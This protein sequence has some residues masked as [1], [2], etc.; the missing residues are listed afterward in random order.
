MNLR[1]SKWTVALALLFLSMLPIGASAQIIK[2]VVVWKTSLQ[3]SDTP[4]KTLVFTATIKSGWHLYDQNLPEDGPT[5]TEFL[6]DKMTGAKLVGK[7]T[8]DKTP[9]DQY[10][11]QFEMN[12]RWYEK[13]VSFRQKI[14]VTDPA[15][16]SIKGGVRFMACNDENCLPPETSDFSF[17]ASMIKSKAAAPITEAE[18]AEADMAAEAVAAEAA[19]D[20]ASQADAAD[21][22]SSKADLWTPVVSELRAYGDDTLKQA[23]SAPWKIF[24]YGF[25][26]GFVALLTPCVWPMIPMTVSFFL[27]RNKDKKKAVRDAF[28][29]GASIIVIYVVLGLLITGIFGVNS[30]NSLATNAV[31]NIIF[32]LLLVVFAISFFG[33]FELVLPSSWTNK[34]D[35]K[36]DSTTGLLSIFFMAFTL[37]LVSFSCTGP[38]IGTLLVQ[39]A[40]AGS[41]LAPAMGMLGFATS[42][43]LPFTLFAV[44]PSWLQ[45]MPKSGGW[46]NMVKVVLGFLELALA[47][48]FL[49]VADLAYGWHI[50]DRETFLALWIVIFALLGCY[51]LG[52]IRFS[53]DSEWPYLSV[54][55]FMMATVSLAFAVYMIPGLWGA[56]LKAVSAFAPPLHTQ[57]FNLY[58]GEVHAHFTDYEAGM[59]FARQENKPVLLDF[60]GHGCVNCRKMEN[61]V[62]IDP[63][64]K[65]M[66]E[67]DYVLI[68]LMVDEKK[69][70]AEPLTIV[71]DG[72]EKTLRT[73]GDKWSYLQSHKFG[74]NAQPFYVAI[75]H[76]GKPLSASYSYNE[77]VPQ[78]VDFLKGGLQEFKKRKNK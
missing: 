71:F 33:A 63:T 48:K 57:D 13:T 45:G 31:F 37:A 67:K 27:K 58:S 43:A 75:D 29:Y 8:P 35:S 10:D 14:Q 39:A 73:V 5:S 72:K 4:E 77:D 15:K 44:F 68:T 60:S 59:A 6:F 7:A 12:L 51:L 78:Y 21:A 18:A 2:D 19:A 34:L 47:L 36:A 69:P 11:K 53:H 22:L 9:I 74:A 64:V 32:F 56:P 24:L 1:N 40:T 25:L 23:E 16:F 61:A 70:L 17:D 66:L 50:L 46:L 49:S 52:W 28:T 41:K 65:S 62:W 3:D 54:P 30:L 42:L 55:R 38:I 76:E 26:Y 20:T